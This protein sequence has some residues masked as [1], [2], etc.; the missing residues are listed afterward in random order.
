MESLP[1]KRVPVIEYTLI[2]GVNDHR[3]HARDLAVLLE[4]FPCKIN[5]IPFNPFSPCDYRRPSGSSVTNFRQIL[6]KAGYTVTVRTTRA[7]DIG[8]ACGQ[9]VGDVADQTSRSDRH[10]NKAAKEAGKV[11][12][13]SGNQAKATDN[14]AVAADRL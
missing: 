10:K 3:Q 9:L 12:E 4:Q 6:Q 7:D 14:L 5:L 13:A 1:D 8:A 2:A 11:F